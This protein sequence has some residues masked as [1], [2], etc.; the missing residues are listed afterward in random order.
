MVWLGYGDKSH[1]QCFGHNVIFIQP[2]R[3]AS[4]LPRPILVPA[5]PAGSQK[6]RRT[7]VRPESAQISNR[8]VSVTQYLPIVPLTQSACVRDR[9]MIPDSNRLKS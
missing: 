3:D 5:S 1:R 2:L 7:P 8:N 9:Q 4:T 6:L